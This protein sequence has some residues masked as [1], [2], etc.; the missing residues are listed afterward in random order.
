[1][2]KM[3]DVPRKKLLLTSKQSDTVQIKYDHFIVSTVSILATIVVILCFLQLIRSDI[4]MP[5]DSTIDTIPEFISN[6]MLQKM[7]EFTTVRIH[8][9]EGFITATV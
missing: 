3:I 7:C 8:L 4:D 9:I 6:P 2:V 5:D 1:M